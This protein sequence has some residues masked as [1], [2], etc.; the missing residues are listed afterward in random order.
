[1]K[2]AIRGR[3]SMGVAAAKEGMGSAWNLH[4]F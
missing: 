3:E 4:A 1:L 2:E